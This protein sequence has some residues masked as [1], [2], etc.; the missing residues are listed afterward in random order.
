MVNFKSIGSFAAIFALTLTVTA[1]V[2][3]YSDE[4]DAR[5]SGGSSFRSSS[6][7]GSSSSFKSYG[8]KAKAKAPVDGL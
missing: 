3:F 4:A 8:S 5:R 6:S 1:P 7:R 2:T